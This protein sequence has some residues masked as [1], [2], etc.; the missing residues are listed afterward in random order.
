[1]KVINAVSNHNPLREPNIEMQ[2]QKTLDQMTKCMESLE[3]KLQASA[4]GTSDVH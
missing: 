3:M 4:E 1:M 2:L